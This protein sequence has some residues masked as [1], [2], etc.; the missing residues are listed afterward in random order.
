MPV[1]I[2]DLICPD[3]RL[4]NRSIRLSEPLWQRIDQLA[5]RLRCRPSSLMRYVIS[6]GVSALEKTDVPQH[7]C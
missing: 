5:L 7:H 1:V 3:E 2:P 6:N 4:Q